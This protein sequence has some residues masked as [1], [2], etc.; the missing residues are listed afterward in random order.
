MPMDAGATS[1]AATGDLV[2]AS[3]SGDRAAFADLVERYRPLACRYAL[4][5]LR[6]RGLAEDACQ[7]AFIEAFQH[8]G[9]LREPAAF[10]GWLRRIVVKHADRQRRR[11]LLYV[12]LSEIPGAHDPL[13]LLIEAEAGREVQEHVALLP[14]HLRD[15]IALFY[16]DGYTVS[17]IA[18]FLEVARGTIRKRLFDG[19]RR[20]RGGLSAGHDERSSAQ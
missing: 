20:L 16:L 6:D 9:Q 13:A 19:R 4:S 5:L 17:E 2:D 14:A 12:E 1:S 3:R 10:P 11:R 7:E 8:L 15:V 18:T